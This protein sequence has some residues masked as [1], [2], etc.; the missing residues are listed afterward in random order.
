[1]SK[2][3]TII[4]AIVAIVV[5]GGGLAAVFLL[6]GLAP[7]EEEL[8]IGVCVAESINDF[9]WSYEVYTSANWIDQAYDNVKVNVFTDLGFGLAV[10]DV[11]TD[12]ADTGYGI[13][14]AHTAA[15]H[16]YVQEVA[17]EYPEVIFA[18]TG[19]PEDN[20][21]NTFYNGWGM[22]ETVYIHGLIAGNFS[23][24]G[25][26]A[27]MDGFK[28]PS[29]N[30]MANA[31]FVGATEVNP[32]V[33]V[34]YVY[35]NTWE[36]MDLAREQAQ[37]LIDSG[38]DVIQ[39]RTSIPGAAQAVSQNDTAYMFGAMADQSSLAPTSIISSVV[40][41]S[42]ALMQFYIEAWFGDGFDD[43]ANNIDL[44]MAD[45][46]NY[47]AFNPTIWD[48]ATLVD[49]GLKAY[50]ENRIAEIQAGTFILVKN[51]THPEG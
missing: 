9:A 16:G 35:A 19:G 36:D 5:V 21:S 11:F 27:Y 23:A 32:L 6:P 45:G 29:T 44:G 40:A 33:N 50:V 37:A 15:Y 41:N 10:K 8:L 24:T 12:L 47:P 22:F 30:E 7:V 42:S 39:A 49:P 25:K 17:E 3:T 28:Y 51:Q 20:I 2:N 26:V 1:M 34:S 13:I 4:V 14:W 38:V 31:F 46:A 48:N 43:V 18:T